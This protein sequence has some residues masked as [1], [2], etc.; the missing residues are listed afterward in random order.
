M[1][2]ACW[3]DPLTRKERRELAGKLAR[4][5]GR[6]YRARLD[7]LDTD[8]HMVAESVRASIDMSDLHLDVTERAEVPAPRSP[9]GRGGHLKSGQSAGSSPA[10]GTEASQ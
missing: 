7:W 5:C 10:G 8:P 6:V 9:D 4:A 3:A 1:T 2:A